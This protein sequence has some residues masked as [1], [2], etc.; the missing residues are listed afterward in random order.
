[1]K[2]IIVDGQFL[3]YKSLFSHTRLTTTF[4]GKEIISGMPFG[5]L[6]AIIE[7]SYKK[8]RKLWEKNRRLGYVHTVD[9]APMV[10][11]PGIFAPS[12]I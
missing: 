2:F 9:I 7:A 10:G 6:K 11:F 8:G 5:F 12:V 3:V 4:K 1:M